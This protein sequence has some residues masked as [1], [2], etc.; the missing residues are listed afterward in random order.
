MV[1]SQV[2][3][4]P[5]PSSIAEHLKVVRKSNDCSI[6]S[7]YNPDRQS[8]TCFSHPA[9]VRVAR[10]WNEINPLS[11]QIDLT[12]DQN[13]LY[14]SIKN[15][16]SGVCK[17][18]EGCWIQKLHMANDATVKKWLKPLKP[19][20]YSWKKFKSM[21]LTTTNLEE[22]MYTYNEL[23]EDVFKFLGVFPINF[24]DTENG[25]CIGR[26][27]CAFRVANL[28]NERKKSF[29]MIL[30]TDKADGS[31]EHWVALYCG[32]DP[33]LPNY[34]IYFYDSNSSPDKRYI[35]PAVRKFT[36]NVTK[37]MHALGKE[38]A[39]FK[40]HFNTFPHQKKDGQ[41]GMFAAVF[42]IALLSGEKY[43][44]YI[45]SNKITDKLM[46]QLRTVFFR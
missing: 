18:D 22:I 9:L 6:L 32:M 27:M 10:N 34:G 37:E 42:I 3:R 31:G 13:T 41:C 29:A 12:T 35:P 46:K 8:Y 5:Q 36:A 2:S 17:S 7:A 44:D 26:F 39:N 11:P 1:N 4:R 33:A 23:F 24:Q 16:M 15:R 38:H 45:N 21:W 25:V 19:E 14:Y 20:R 40:E 43:E 30:N 28:I